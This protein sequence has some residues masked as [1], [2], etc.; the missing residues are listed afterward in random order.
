MNNV[1][2]GNVAVGSNLG[3]DIN[4]QNG[5]KKDPKRPYPQ[6]SRSQYKF[7]TRGH[8]FGRFEKNK[9]HSCVKEG[10]RQWEKFAAK[11]NCYCT[12]LPGKWTA[13]EFYGRDN[14]QECSYDD[15]EVNVD[16]VSIEEVSATGVRR[17][18][19]LYTDLTLYANGWPT[20]SGLAYNAHALMFPGLIST[21]HMQAAGD[22][23]DC[24][25]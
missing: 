15:C 6:T 12:P 2:V 1:F 25:R 14:I 13:Q 23:V 20:F 21:T 16:D 5:A 7:Y 8:T 4:V 24:A 11:V 9:A 18:Y 10:F 17:G 3:F 19:S 22:H